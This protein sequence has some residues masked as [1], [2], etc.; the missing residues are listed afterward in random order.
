M[1]VKIKKLKNLVIQTIFVEMHI[2]T[3]VSDL[4][5]IANFEND[6]QL[7]FISLVYI[8]QTKVKV[9]FMINTKVSRRT[10]V[11]RK[12]VKLYKF[13]IAR[14]QKSIKLQLT[15]DKL[16][17]NI[18]HMTQLTFSLNDHIDT[19]WCLI[20]N[21]SKYDIIINMFWLQKHDS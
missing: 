4:K 14:L 10:F 19:C 18:I 20:T 6:Y 13:F 12:Y 5:L 21:L 2:L 16:I 17:L 8:S 7:N 3:F 1:H 11:N 15:N 9:A